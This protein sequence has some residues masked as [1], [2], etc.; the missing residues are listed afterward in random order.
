MAL[1]ISMIFMGVF[2]YIDSKTIRG[3]D[4]LVAKAQEVLPISKDTITSASYGGI[5]RE[6]N[7]ALVWILSDNGYDSYDYW[8]MKYNIV[9]E[10]AYTFIE[11]SRPTI[12]EKDIV[13]ALWHGTEVF[14]IND[15]SCVA[16]QYRDNEGAIIFEDEIKKGSY[17]YV[18]ALKNSSG[19]IDFIDSNGKYIS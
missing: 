4:E 18:Y 9:G 6:D 8:S 7:E 16:V 2:I 17:P 14:L 15:E 11:W 1:V 12:Y 10:N 13:S 5:W 19:K 3:R